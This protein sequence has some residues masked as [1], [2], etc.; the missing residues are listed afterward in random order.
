VDGPAPAVPVYYVSATARGPR[1]YRE[2]H[3]ATGTDA[4]Q[5]A[6]SDAVGR[7]DDPDYHS[8]W[9]AGTTVTAS[10]GDGAITLDLGSSAGSLAPRPAGTTPDQAKA[11][12]QQL[13]HTAQAATRT[14]APVQLTLD[15]K[16]SDTVLGEPTLGAT[17]RGKAA[18]VLGQVWV[19]S[20]GNGA[21]VPSTFE[22]TG[23]AA[24]FEATVQWELKRG[25]AVVR[26]GFTTAQQCC[27]MA[28]YS[29]TVHA[30]AGRYTLVVHDTDAS[31]DG[32]PLWQDTK[33]ITVR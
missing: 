9:P 2:F 26:K 13:V 1:L 30:P 3:A 8:G 33:E 20:P 11:A 7:A 15:G 17:E 21:T 6:V 28:P 32:A 12:L 29:F 14:T 22:V 25:D 18:D 23:L 10:V 27:V 24:A 31:G 5:Q 4:L 19:V 16:V